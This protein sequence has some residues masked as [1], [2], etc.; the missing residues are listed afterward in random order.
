[1]TVAE[2]TNKL[3][4]NMSLESELLNLVTWDTVWD[5]YTLECQL[6]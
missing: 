6:K 2:R 4:N 5:M 3:G 1:M